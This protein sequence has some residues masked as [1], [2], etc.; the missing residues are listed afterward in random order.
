MLLFAGWQMWNQGKILIAIAK[1]KWCDRL[2]NLIHRST[3]TMKAQV[4]TIDLGFAKFDGLMLP[5]GEYAI[6]IPQVATL[7]QSIPNTASRDFKRLLGE[8]FNPSKQSIEGTKALVNVVGL[9]FQSLLRIK[10]YY[11]PHSTMKYQYQLT[12]NPC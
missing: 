12:F 11:N 5:N 1:L 7:I 8:S 3:N 9:H 10:I 4:A 6:A 2:A